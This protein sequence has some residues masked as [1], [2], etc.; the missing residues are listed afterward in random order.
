MLKYYNKNSSIY[1]SKNYYK[2]TQGN[3]SNA[4]IRQKQTIKKVFHVEQYG[5]DF[6][7]PLHCGQQRFP[8]CTRFSRLQVSFGHVDILQLAVPFWKKFAS[9]KNV[10]HIFSHHLQIIQKSLNVDIFL[11][12]K[13][14]TTQ[15]SVTQ[16]SALDK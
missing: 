4:W 8:M 16:M 9:N 3:S 12:L 1:I 15:T 10:K 14:F 7:V 6:K 2:M 13:S 5:E 11:I